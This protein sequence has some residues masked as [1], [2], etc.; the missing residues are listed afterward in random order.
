MTVG[1]AS[2]NGYL[3]RVA[4]AA[5][6]QGEEKQ[7]IQRSFGRLRLLLKRH[8]KKQINDSFPFGSFSRGTILPRRL[9]SRSDVDF[10]VVFDDDGSRPQTYIDR[11]RRFVEANY[12]QS[13]IRQS[14][15]TVQLNLNH[16]TFD[17]V[18][19]ISAFWY[20]Y[21]IPLQSTDFTDWMGTDPK[22]FNVDLSQANQENKNLIK[23]LTRVMKYWN[24][25]SGY[26]FDSYLLEQR[27]VE[28]VDHG[29][30]LRRRPLFIKEFVYDFSQNGIT[31]LLDLWDAKWKVGAVSRLRSSIDNIR[32]AE[33]RLNIPEAVSHLEKLLPPPWLTQ[34]SSR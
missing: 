25:S 5:F 22:G 11:L 6:V 2:V 8:F 3:M 19:A 9:D 29:F 33:Q 1:Q 31:D 21:N 10:M 13:E 18:P 17:I 15:P 30:F 28:H 32:E 14:H 7:S 23:P 16:I 4:R 27:I 12:K 34:N 24:A 26:P 20:G